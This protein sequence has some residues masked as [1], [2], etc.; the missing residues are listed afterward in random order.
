M[1]LAEYGRE[2]RTAE[3]EAAAGSHEAGSHPHPGP[4]EYLQIG[5]VLAV[6]TGLEVAIYY[7]DISHNL[8]A[9]ILLVLSALKF[10]LVV[11]WFMHLKF[12]NRLFANMFVGGLLLALAL[13]VVVLATMGAGLV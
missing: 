11:L 7:A 4:L 1:T 10:S 3:V 13:F 6:M 9:G 5:L 2:K 8:L 12:D